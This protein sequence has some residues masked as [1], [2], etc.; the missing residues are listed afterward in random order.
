MGRTTELRR[1]LKATFI[2]HAL[3]RGFDMDVRH[4]PLFTVFRRTVGSVVQVFEIQWEKYGSPRFVL[5]FGDVPLDGTHISGAPIIPQ[6]IQPHDCRPRL[7]LQR[8][9]GGSLACWFQLRKP[10]WLQLVTLRRDYTPAEV[11]HELLSAYPEME[12]WWQSRRT[13]AHVH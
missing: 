2:P 7:R 13:G 12:E 5:N 8:R 10:L 4:Q 6:E 3:A 9:R 1:A 11:V